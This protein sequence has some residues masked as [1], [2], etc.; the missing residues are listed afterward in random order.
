MMLNDKKT[1]K[2]LLDYEVKR[3]FLFSGSMYF[4]IDE[5]STEDFI[6]SLC[7]E[8]FIDIIFQEKNYQIVFT[9]FNKN[10]VSSRSCFRAD[11][12]VSSIYS[13]REV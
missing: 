12:T 9:S 4:S 1:N 6:R 7:M 8:S 3:G 2:E 11:F 10:N 13:L 5:I